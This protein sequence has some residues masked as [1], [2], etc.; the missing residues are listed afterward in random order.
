MP[1]ALSTSVPAPVSSLGA[2]KTLLPSA[3]QSHTDITLADLTP[4]LPVKLSPPA[5]ASLGQPETARPA[6]IFAPSPAL[7]VV[8]EVVVK[9]DAL[10]VPTAPARLSGVPATTLTAL[11]PAPL[12][13][14]LTQSVETSGQIALQNVAVPANNTGKTQPPQGVPASSSDEATSPDTTMSSVKGAISVPSQVAQPSEKSVTKVD[15]ALGSTAGSGQITGLGNASRDVNQGNGPDDEALDDQSSDDAR[16]ENTGTPTA[17]PLPSAPLTE[18]Q[19]PVTAVTDKPLTGAERAQVVRQT[20]DGI[21]TIK[22]HVAA[23]GQGRMTVQLHPKEWG[24]LRVTVQMTPT[25]PVDGV[26]QTSV[27][28]HVVASSPAVKAALETQAADLNH[29]LRQTGLQLERLTVTVQAPGADAQAG[30][31]TSGDRSSGSNS[32]DQWQSAQAQTGNSGMGA[33]SSSSF[34]SY[35]ERQGGNSFQNPSMSRSAYTGGD[36]N[37][38]DLLPVSIQMIRPSTGFDQRA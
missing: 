35:S 6:Q 31:S 22:P 3:R 25:A 30:S 17:M 8:P 27:V 19:T 11:T 15:T 9:P 36:G 16:Q 32:Q 14:G 4:A 26:K 2:V 37:D 13:D 23:A 5:S 1:L 33:G 20:A 12:S 7:E 18:T 24:D 10:G 21:G 29:A 28:A 38:T 34:T